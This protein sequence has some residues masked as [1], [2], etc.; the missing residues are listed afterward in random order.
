MS[1]IHLSA[2]V[3]TTLT[4]VVILFQLCLAA[5]APYPSAQARHFCN[6]TLCILRA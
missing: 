2:L 5:G 1:T 3:F 4:A 6:D